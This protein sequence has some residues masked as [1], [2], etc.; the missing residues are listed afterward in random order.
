MTRQEL[1]NFDK[2]YMHPAM[3]TMNFVTNIAGA[4]IVSEDIKLLTNSASDTG[5]SASNKKFLSSSLNVIA[6]PPYFIY[7]FT[8]IF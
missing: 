8:L 6:S 1:A 5:F 4:M 7:C 2:R 3:P